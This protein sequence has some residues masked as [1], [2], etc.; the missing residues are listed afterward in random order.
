VNLF[1]AFLGGFFIGR[2]V[3]RWFRRRRYSQPLKLTINVRKQRS[4]DGN[5]NSADSPVP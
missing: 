1:F 3:E 2:I 4:P 5:R